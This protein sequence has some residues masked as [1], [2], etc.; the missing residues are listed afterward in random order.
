M[1]IFVDMDGV[2]ANFDKLRDKEFSETNPFPQS[3]VGFFYDL[4]PMPGAIYGLLE[5]TKKHDTVI[6]TKPS[7]KNPHCWTE[8][9]LWIEEYFG[10]KQAENM[11]VTARKEL[12]APTGGYLIDDMTD[13]GQLAFGDKL[14]KFNSHKSLDCWNN[15][16]SLFR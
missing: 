10:R 6:L 2:L 9:A 8:K 15:I 13:S 5:L 11:I 3:R 14:I 7:V 4:E 1:L 16:V 12:L